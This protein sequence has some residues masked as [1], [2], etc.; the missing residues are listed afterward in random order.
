MPL[1]S[2]SFERTLARMAFSWAGGSSAR[3]SRVY[4]PIGTASEPIAIL[5]PPSARSSRPAISESLGTAR[6]NSL[7]ANS[8]GLE[9]RP[10]AF[11][12]SGSRVLAAA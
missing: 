8:I 9:S 4:S 10:S 6:T 11:S 3:V 1:T 12:S 7:V 5:T 2:G